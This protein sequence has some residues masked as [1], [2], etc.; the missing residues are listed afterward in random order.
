MSPAGDFVLK[1][2]AQPDFATIY[3]HATHLT[4]VAKKNKWNAHLPEWGRVFPPGHRVAH[5]T[6]PH[7]MPA[8]VV[9][10]ASSGIG[11]IRGH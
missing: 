6:W 9:V 11:T 7:K 10:D 5:R 2:I 1:E 4:P 8:K 3:L